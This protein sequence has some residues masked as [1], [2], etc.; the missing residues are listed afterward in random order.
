MRRWL[1]MTAVT[2]VAG[3][4]ARKIADRSDQKASGRKKRR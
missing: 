2:A 4:V 3:F 1:I